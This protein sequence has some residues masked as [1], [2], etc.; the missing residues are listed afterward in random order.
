[1]IIK[2]LSEAT[3]LLYGIPQAEAWGYGMMTA[4]RAVKSK[5]D[6]NK[7]GLSQLLGKYGWGYNY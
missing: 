2:R 1:M 4:L 5:W 7:Y 3:E 6:I